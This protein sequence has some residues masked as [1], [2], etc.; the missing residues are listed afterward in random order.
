MGGVCGTLLV[1]GLAWFCI[2][3]R[4]TAAAAGGDGGLRTSYAGG[5]QLEGPGEEVA[6]S[7]PTALHPYNAS[8]SSPLSQAPLPRCPRLAEA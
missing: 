1:A 8:P 4:K 5:R 3:R 6:H 2:K 7:R